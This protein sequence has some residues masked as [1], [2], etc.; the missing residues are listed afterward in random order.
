MR[1]PEVKPRVI[2]GEF[3]T[4]SLKPI[5][6]FVRTSAQHT[7]IRGEFATASLK[8]SD[9]MGLDS[10]STGYPWRIRHGLIEATRVRRMTRVAQAVIRGEFATASLKPMTPENVRRTLGR[11][12]WRIRHGLIE[13]IGREA[14]KQRDVSLSVANSPRP[15]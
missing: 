10:E 12:P 9:N 13:A 3:A 2:R 7:V 8:L 5:L 11:Y 15:H 14:A 4:A 6:S 1:S